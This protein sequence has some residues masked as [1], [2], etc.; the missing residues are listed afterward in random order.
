ML[1]YIDWAYEGTTDGNLLEYYCTHHSSMKG[2]F[3]ILNQDSDPATPYDAL[4]PTTRSIESGNN[5]RLEIEGE[6]IIL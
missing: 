4:V 6:E 5:I 1:V 2:D 3:N